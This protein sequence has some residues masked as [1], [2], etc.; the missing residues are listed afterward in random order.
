MIRL[1]RT[2]TLKQIEGEMRF[3]RN[4]VSELNKKARRETDALAEMAKV[5]RKADE[6]YGAVLKLIADCFGAINYLDLENQLLLFD[7]DCLKDER[8]NYREKCQNAGLLNEF[9]EDDNF[10]KG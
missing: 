9:D 3:L 8:D 4:A 5:Y 2:R 7:R 10:I 6:A 1:I